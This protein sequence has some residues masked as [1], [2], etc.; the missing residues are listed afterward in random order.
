MS[1]IFGLLAY[2]KPQNYYNAVNGPDGKFW[3]TAVE[4]DLESLNT[5]KTWSITSLPANKKALST[6]WIFKRKMLPGGQIDKFKA[7]LVARG[8]E[9]R[10]GVDFL[11]T[12]APVARHATIRSLFALITHKR[13]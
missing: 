5:N 7:R 8:V 3:R 2:E 9:Q 11:E 6:R 4:E 12:Y 1:G 10:P 13:Y